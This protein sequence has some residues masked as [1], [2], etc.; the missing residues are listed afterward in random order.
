MTIEEE[1]YD[2]LSVYAGLAALV[3]TRI[4]R[5][6]FPDNVVKPAIK[7]QRI[8]TQREY[9]HQGYS[10]LARPLFQFSCFGESQPATKAAIDQVR[11]A[12]QGY[13]G[14]MGNVLV[15]GAIVVDE[16]SD[17]EPDTRLFRYDIDVQIP[18]DET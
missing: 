9:S 14:T 15:Q 17:Y 3:G 6:R 7:Y 12:L 8:D 18:H 16:R 10:G 13:A 11:I 2:Y 5:D 1:L 4:Y